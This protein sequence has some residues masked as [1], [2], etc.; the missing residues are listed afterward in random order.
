MREKV[1]IITGAS[2]E[3]GQN[4]ILE[5]EKLNNK[6]IVAIDLNKPIKANCIYRFYQNSIL[7]ESLLDKL[8]KNYIIEEI[9]HLAAV[10]STKAE[11]N[12]ILAEEVNIKGTM[13]LF[14]LALSQNK[15]NNI[16]TKFFFPSSI[17]VYN[18]YSCINKDEIISEESYCNPITVYGKNKLFCENLGTSFNKYGNAAN[19]FL[20]F[21]CI[22]FPGIISANSMPTGGTSDYAPELIHNAFKK[23]NYICFVN[24]F[25]RLPF[26]VMP[27]AIDAIIQMMKIN[28][29][30]LNKHVYNIQ[31]FSP[32][33]N[34]LCIIINTKLP[35]FSLSYNV[36]DMRQS[37]VDNWPNFIDDVAARNDWKWNPKYNLESAFNNYLQPK[38]E[39]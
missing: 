1:T 7:D 8:N 16:L 35:N 6:K 25:T 31:S 30:N 28:K 22:R 15:K 21:R 12:P 9:F 39:K 5:F 37:I 2:G 10:L 14:D 13:N 26:I 3:I 23:N 18:T 32:T 17:A 38:L 20:D 11:K 19:A 33:V 27:D 36:D 4:L 34:D 29:K 24:E